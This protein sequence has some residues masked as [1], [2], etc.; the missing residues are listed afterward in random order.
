MTKQHTPQPP[1][2]PNKSDKA[3]EA[4]AGAHKPAP[5]PAAARADDDLDDNQQPSLLQRLIDLILYLPHFITQEIWRTRAL[6]ARSWKGRSYGFL[7][8]AALTIDGIL[9]NRLAVQAAA[10]G[11]YTLIALG[12]LVAIAIMISGF[13]IK[14]NSKER[15]VDALTSL[16]YFIAPPA[17]QAANQSSFQ[18]YS[19]AQWP[20]FHPDAEPTA[21]PPP[22]PDLS[23]EHAA[24]QI[25]PSG[26]LVNVINMLVNNARSGTMGVVGSLT[27]II[28]SIGLIS[29]IEKT[30]NAIWGV[31]RGRSLVQQVIIYWTLITLGAVIGVA[32]LTLGMANI[33][34]E[35]FEQLPLGGTFLKDLFLWA[36]PI[37][38]FLLVTVLLASFYRFIPNTRVRWQPAFIGAVCVAL[39]LYANQALSF[40][41]IGF[42][43]RQGSLFGAVGI[44][45]VLLFGLFIFWLFLLLGG[46]IT[47]AIQNVNTLTHQRVWNNVSHR[48]QEL[49]ALTALLLVC[50]RYDQCQRPYSA[51]EL[52]RRIRVPANILNSTLSRL[53][54]IGYLIVVTPPL[55]RNEEA[56]ERYQPGRPLNKITLADFKETFEKWGNNDGTVIL[57]EL[58]P[59]LGYY[60]RQL[61]QIAADS[62]ART[63]LQ[64]LLARA[65]IAET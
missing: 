59:L 46:Q 12:P 63:S 11:Y 60:N 26:Q 56:Q 49:L 58:D 14:D 61:L 7:R 10:L 29:N 40:L 6:E 30:F 53:C 39:L 20:S 17:E 28:I 19:D 37:L 4:K 43:V 35:T 47:Y 65:D 3:Y 36:S 18:F 15:I 55:A 57:K 13:V 38:A 44:L 33:A 32:A 54:S 48:T 23:H 27:L 41:Y 5:L 50:R 9:S 42:V 21:T 52:A 34:A 62:P 24:E 45:P 31:P 64:D 22:V 51:G 16:T 25:K 1:Q 2:E 8:M